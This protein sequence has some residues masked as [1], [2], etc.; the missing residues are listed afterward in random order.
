LKRLYAFSGS[1]P[2]LFVICVCTL[3]LVWQINFLTHTPLHQS[4]N[5]TCRQGRRQEFATGGKR[6]VLGTE[7]R[8]AQSRGRAPVGVWGEAPPPEDGVLI[9]NYDGG[10]S[11]MPPLG[12]ATACYMQDYV[13]FGNALIIFSAAKLR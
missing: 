5:N 10:H 9:S 2:H 4:Q 11:P 8:P 12:Y 1:L 13:R 6:G 3:F 7:V